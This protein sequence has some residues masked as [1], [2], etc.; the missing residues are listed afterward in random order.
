MS[1]NKIT[2]TEAM[3]EVEKIVTR[4]RSGELN[5]DE[6]SKEVARATALIA[7]CRTIL[8]RTEEDV[9]RLINPTTEDETSN[10]SNS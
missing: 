4:L 9:E 5:V 2:Y 8:T 3:A 10:S 1:N 7:E 6:L